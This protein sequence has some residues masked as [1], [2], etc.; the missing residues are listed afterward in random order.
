MSYFIYLYDLLSGLYICLISF[1]FYHFLRL[2]KYKIPKSSLPKIHFSIIIPARNEC[3]N[4]IKC[5]DSVLA[6]TYPTNFY[7][8]IVIDDH[9][10]DNTKDLV[11]N[12][13]IDHPNVKILEL[14]DFSNNI[15]KTYKKKA[16]EYGIQNSRFEWII[17][18]DADCIV[19]KK[20]LEN[21]NNF[22]IQN[23][24][25]FVVAP[26]MFYNE[27][28]FINHFQV[29]DFMS[30]QGITAGMVNANN[31]TM[32]NGANLAYQKKSFY[33]IEGFKG[34]SKQASGDDMLLMSKFKNKFKNK[35]H[36]LFSD[37]SIVLT[38]AMPTVHKFL[39][40]RIRW[41]SKTNA[42]QEKNMV[43]A[44]GLIYFY[45]LI[46]ICSCVLVIIYPS[47]FYNWLILLVIR[48]LIEFIFLWKVSIFYKSQK[49]L[50]WFLPIQFVYSFYVILAGFLG[51]FQKYEWKGRTIEK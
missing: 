5:L 14:K 11:S 6:Q 34:I 7:E 35:I 33:E 1:Y 10:E 51:M 23:E 26:V 38:N 28:N 39:Q 8:I 42:Y 47:F 9:S 13:Q 17:T 24:S 43:T 36:Y 41:A 4:I 18:T 32:C 46:F 30:L 15:N 3:W 16:I 27:P 48:L 12:Y 49:T 45:N 2:K 19:P 22:I 31:Y 29:L 50:K 44:L 21:L 20:W 25:T 40:Q 37:E